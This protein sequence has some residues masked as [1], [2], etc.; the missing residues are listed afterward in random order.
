MPVERATPHRPADDLHILRD[1]AYYAP[2][3]M[4]LTALG[5]K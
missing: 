4:A 5:A 2:R 1:R 3:E